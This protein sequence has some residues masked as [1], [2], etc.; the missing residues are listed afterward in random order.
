MSYNHFE[1]RTLN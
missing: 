1:R